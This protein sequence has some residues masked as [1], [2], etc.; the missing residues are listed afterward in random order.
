MGEIHHIY[1][2]CDGS[3]KQSEGGHESISQRHLG[4][5]VLTKICSEKKKVD[6]MVCAA[7]VTKREL[8]L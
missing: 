4:S 1:I 7:V 3:S 8:S 5:N 6:N 2:W